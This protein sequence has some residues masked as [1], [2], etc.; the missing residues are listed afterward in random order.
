MNFDLSTLGSE[1]VKMLFL[2]FSGV[3]LPP[4]INISKSEKLSC[5]A[6]LVWSKPANNGCPLT[7]Y[8]VYYRQIQPRDT[9]NPWYEINITDVSRTR[10]ALSLQ[11]DTQ[12]MI[13]ISAWNELG[14]SDRSNTWLTTINSG[15]FPRRESSVITGVGERGFKDGASS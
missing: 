14:K 7:M 10:H 9:G 1:R 15:T 11:C 8:S 13:E 2:T 3:P 12:Y 6:S 5:N 4:T